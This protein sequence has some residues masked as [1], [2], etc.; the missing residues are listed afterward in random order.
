M[1]TELDVIERR[2]ARPV[3]ATQ[4]QPALTVNPFI[5]AESY[6]LAANALQRRVVSM[7]ETSGGDA[8]HRRHR[9]AGYQ[10]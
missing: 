7:I 8:R 4:A 6:A 1:Q 10:R 9:S 2:M 3:T 5:N